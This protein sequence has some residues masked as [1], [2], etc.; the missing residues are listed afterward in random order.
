VSKSTA[1]RLNSTR[2]R[3]IHHP[4]GNDCAIVKADRYRSQS[5]QRSRSVD[6]YSFRRNLKVRGAIVDVV[7]SNLTVQLSME[8]EARFASLGQSVPALASG[9]K[10]S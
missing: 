8:P 9:G 2:E 1:E 3:D 7:A 6:R 10:L 5:K 4:F